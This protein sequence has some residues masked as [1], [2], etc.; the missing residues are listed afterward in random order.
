MVYLPWCLMPALLMGDNSPRE[1]WA[2]LPQ[3][4]KTLWILEA[5]YLHRECLQ[6]WLLKG[7]DILELLY[8]QCITLPSPPP[9]RASAVG[10]AFQQFR[11]VLPN[12]DGVA[13]PHIV[14][15]RVPLHGSLPPSGAPPSNVQA[16][17]PW[18]HAISEPTQRPW[19]H[20][21]ICSI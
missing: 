1:A 11:V 18:T 4:A 12:A 13:W 16:G 17:H 19:Y 15:Q 10:A 21:K 14:I 9:L 20:Q 3:C 6:F 8:Y 5:W 7:S 2:T